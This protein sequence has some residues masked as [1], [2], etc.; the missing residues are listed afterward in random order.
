MEG[1]PEE[2]K[3]KKGIFSRMFDKLDKL[4]EEKS[5]SSS[6]CC[7]PSNKENKSCCS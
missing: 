6:C 1:K 2:K 3:S 5:K 7:K 4:M